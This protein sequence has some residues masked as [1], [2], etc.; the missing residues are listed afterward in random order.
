MIRGESGQEEREMKAVVWHGTEGVRVNEVSDPTIQEPTDAIVRITS[1]AICGS[2]LH[3]YK[4]VLD[5][6]GPVASP[7]GKG[8]ETLSGSADVTLT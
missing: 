3:L 2:D 1:T 8:A 5:V 4:G 6:H 7:V